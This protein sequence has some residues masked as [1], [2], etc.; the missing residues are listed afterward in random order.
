MKVTKKLQ[1]GLIILILLTP[2]GLLLPALS[3]AGDAWGEW[4]SEELG[5]MLGYVPAGVSRLSSLWKAPLADY[6]LQGQQS[7]PPHLQGAL[8][9]ISA[10]LGAAVAAG[11]IV[12]I[13]R[14]FTRNEDTENS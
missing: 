13:G 8:Y 9:I 2:L 5:K 10:I 1:T 6:S 7:A 12:L 4:S 11:V 14:F 3:G